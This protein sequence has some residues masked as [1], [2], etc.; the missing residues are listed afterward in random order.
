MSQFRSTTQSPSPME[1]STVEFVP[2]LGQLTFGCAT[3]LLIQVL[4]F[5]CGERNRAFEQFP[6]LVGFEVAPADPFKQLL[7]G[8]ER[9][10]RCGLFQSQPLQ[11]SC[12]QRMHRD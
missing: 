11:L 8:F 1:R 6:P 7:P 3:E 9:N 5:F 10:R 4:H 2:L 12:E